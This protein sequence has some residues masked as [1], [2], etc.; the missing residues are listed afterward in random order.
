MKRVW[1]GF[2]GSCYRYQTEEPEDEWHEA[3]EFKWF[4]RFSR[5]LAIYVWILR[6]LGIK[7]GMCSYLPGRWFER[8]L[9]ILFFP[10]KAIKNKIW[11]LFK[12]DV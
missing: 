11:W 5:K 9:R 2:Y 8:P 7:Q 3:N 1:H 4:S 6:R 12:S 10:W